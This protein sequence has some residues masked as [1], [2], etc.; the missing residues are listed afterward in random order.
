MLLRRFI[1]HVKKQHW[2]AI[3]IDFVIVVLGVFIGLQVNTWNQA[4]IE[5][6]QERHYLQ[7]LREDFVASIAGQTRDINFLRQQLSDQA[8]ILKSLD[9]CAAAPADDAAF[10]RG[11]NALGFVNPPRFYRRTVDELSAAGKTDVI[12]NETIKDRLADILYIVQWRT[13]S[14]DSAARLTEHYRYIIEEQNRFDFSRSS[15]DAFLGQYFAVTYDIGKLCRNP[16]IASAVSAVSYHTHE[17]LHAYLEV[18]ERYKA[19]LPLLDD[20]LRSRWGV[21]TTALAAHAP[22]RVGRAP[23]TQSTVQ[24]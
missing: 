1:E 22:G 4:R 3:A 5:R 15:A 24:Q 2:T 7:R 14:Y 16:A 17:R 23:A 6:S 12:Q 9:R 11:L 20:E 21:D 8:V 10:Q 18:L 19:F 13:A